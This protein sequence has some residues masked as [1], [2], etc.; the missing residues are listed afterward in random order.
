MSRV[1]DQPERVEHG[2]L[3]PDLFDGQTPIVWVA[4]AVH[5]PAGDSHTQ[6]ETG[7]KARK[8]AQREEVP[9]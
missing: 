5:R 7:K 4:G 2:P 1:T 8:R 9:K 3:H 6:R